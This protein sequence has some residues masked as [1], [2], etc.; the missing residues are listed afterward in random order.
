[1]EKLVKGLR[2]KEKGKR[3]KKQETSKE[4][5]EHTNVNYIVEFDKAIV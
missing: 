2:E 3:E 4:R 1:M 5:L